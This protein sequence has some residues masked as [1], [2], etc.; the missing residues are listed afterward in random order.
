M[1]KSIIKTALIM[2][3]MIA[4]VAV[5]SPASAIDWPQFQK[6]EIHTGWTTDG[7]PIFNPPTMIW[8][9]HTSG[10]GMGGIDVT[11]IVGDGDV[12]VL[13]YQGILW[14][15]D[16][17]TGVENWNTD[18]T[19]GSGTFEL[20]TPAYHDGIIYAAVSSGSE[21]EGAGRICAVRASDGSIRESCY[22]GYQYYQI[23]TPVTYSDGKIYFGNWKGGAHITEDWGTYYCVN[24]DNVC[25]L[26]WS[27]TSSYETGYYWAGGAIVGDFII[28]GDDRANILCL[29]KDDGT[30]VDNIDVSSCI[31]PVEEIRSSIT[32]NDD[33]NRIYFT[34]KK[35][36]PLSGHAYAVSFNQVTGDLGNSCEWVTD[37]GYSTSTPVV[38]NTE[39]GRRV[40]VCSGGM[41]GNG[42]GIH[43][44]N[45]QNGNILHSATPDRSQ[46]SPAVS[47]INGDVY[48]YF[49]TNVND[50][51]AYCYKDNQNGI[52]PMWVWNPPSPDGQFILQGMAVADGVI[53]F[54][55]DYGE[56]Y[57]LAG[58]CG[59]VDCDGGVNVADLYP[60][61]MNAV[62]SDHI[63]N[64]W[65]A[66][67]DC[68]GGVNVA[69]LYPLFMNAIHGDP[70]N[71]CIE[72]Q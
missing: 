54:G 34:G 61:F 64:K 62:N 45:E 32:W 17:M 26:I 39:W 38:Y 19:A 16:A 13:D 2:S 58:I 43:V 15:F 7:G 50:G 72:S 55:T 10:T 68:D 53:Y 14:S 27:R 70:L 24:A 3:V 67:V 66:D 44:L 20:S 42:G 37:I 29:D 12:Y 31:T 51:S 48:A 47:I 9:Q 65:G 8:S 33:T 6:D 56:L 11:P 4:V 36:S 46:A 59:D 22:Y 35:A 60:L 1:N 40:Y 52:T 23:N 18:L 21:G 63:C 5:I 41:Y 28:F 71:C 69:D 49:T 25:N 57:A 30:F